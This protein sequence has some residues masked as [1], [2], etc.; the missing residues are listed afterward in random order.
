MDEK[1]RSHVADA[2]RNV[3]LA[4]GKLERH[5]RAHPDNAAVIE[6]VVEANLRAVEH[7]LKAA[8]E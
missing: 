3:T 1:T 2:K 8:L 6:T 4:I 5:A 7:A